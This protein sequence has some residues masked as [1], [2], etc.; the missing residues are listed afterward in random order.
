M[1]QTINRSEIRFSTCAGQTLP[2]SVQSLSGQLPCNAEI[3]DISP[4]GAKFVVSAPLRCDDQMTVSM[5]VADAGVDVQIVGRICW[6]RLARDYRWLV[7]ALFDEPLEL[8]ELEK[9]ASAGYIEQR[10][11][12]RTDVLIPGKA[13]RETLAQD[14]DVAIT[15]LSATGFRLAS[16]QQMEPG[17]RV[18]VGTDLSEGEVAFPAHVRWSGQLR[19][20]Y[21]VGCE[22]VDQDAFQHL[23][24]HLPEQ[25][26]ESEPQQAPRRRFACA[27]GAAVAIGIAT[28]LYRAELPQLADQANVVWQSAQPSLSH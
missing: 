3:I 4:S 9:L 2:A 16:P 17:E 26:P 21:S 7:G 11:A 23:K 24:H 18:L 20:E 5:S 8:E 6:I 13:R 22:F 14:M 1:T 15:N 12:P 19:D 10:S 27:L 25:Q 28:W